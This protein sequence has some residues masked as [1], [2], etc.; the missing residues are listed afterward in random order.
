MAIPSRTR[1]AQ[2]TRSQD[3][4]LAVY[5]KLT[6]A[7]EDQKDLIPQVMCVTRVLLAY[8][9]PQKSGAELGRGH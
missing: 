2:L 5:L 1:K 7:L 9:H 8:F 6:L 3:L 4:F